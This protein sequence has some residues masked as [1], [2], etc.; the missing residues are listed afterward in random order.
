MQPHE[1]TTILLILT[2]PTHPKP[3]F[4]SLTVTEPEYNL[5]INSEI[6]TQASTHAYNKDV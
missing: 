5:T 1:V 4:Y 6:R 2:K 3:V